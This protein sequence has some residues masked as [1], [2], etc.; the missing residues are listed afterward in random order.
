MSVI[1]QKIYRLVENRLRDRWTMLPRARAA[2]YAAQAAAAAPPGQ[3]TD[4]TPVQGGGSDRTQAAVLRVIQAEERLRQAEKWA[5][6]FALLDETFP[7]E[8]TAEGV[9]AGYLYGNGMTQEEVCRATHCDRQ[10]VRRRRDNY[11]AHC[12]LFAAAEGLIRIEEEE[13]P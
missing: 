8:G 10:T 4:K 6:V 9:V 5:A 1:P 13:N 2:L 7:F 3:A 11:V 12:A